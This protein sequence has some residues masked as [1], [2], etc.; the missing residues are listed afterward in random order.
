[1][2]RLPRAQGHFERPPYTASTMRSA[3]HVR[4]LE[5]FRLAQL[6]RPLHAF[7]SHDWPRGI[8]RFGNAG[9]LCRAKSFLAAEV[10]SPRGLN[11]RALTPWHTL[12]QVAAIFQRDLTQQTAS[13][14]RGPESVG[15]RPFRQQAFTPAMQ[16]TLDSMELEMLRRQVFGQAA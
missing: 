14:A 6:K 11:L 2:T 8:A 15:C 7:L 9:A 10:R 3:Y 16:Q 13:S 12:W 1:M 5:M 4:E